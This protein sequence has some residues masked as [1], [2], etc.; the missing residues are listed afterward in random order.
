M[1]QWQTIYKTEKPYQAEIVKGILNDRGINSV[2]V[3]KQD[4]SYHFGFYEVNV[5]RENVLEA[6]QIIENDINFK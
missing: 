5:E 2:I 6:I 3:N 1:S 4:S